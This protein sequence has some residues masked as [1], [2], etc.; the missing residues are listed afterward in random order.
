MA[1]DYD[2]RN[3]DCGM[4]NFAKAIAS[5]LDVAFDT[6]L[7]TAMD[8]QVVFVAIPAVCTPNLVGRDRSN[9]I[10]KHERVMQRSV[11]PRFNRHPK[12]YDSAGPETRY[13]KASIENI[14]KS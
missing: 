10:G 8:S 11:A 3:E 12:N 5:K 13:L 4:N 9:A 2:P 1:T 14:L 6:A 7:I